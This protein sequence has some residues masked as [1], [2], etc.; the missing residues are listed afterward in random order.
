MTTFEIR[1]PKSTEATPEPFTH[2]LATLANQSPPALLRRLFMGESTPAVFL[3]LLA[4]KQAIHYLFSCPEYLKSY[5]TNQLAAHY[6]TSQFLEA[7]DLT[8]IFSSQ[9]A[10]NRQQKTG[11]NKHQSSII[12]HQSSIINELAYG[13]MELSHPY[14]YPINTYRAFREKDPMASILSIL[15]RLDEHESALVQFVLMPAGSGWQESTQRMLDAGTTDPTTKRRLALPNER[16][17]RE[18]IVLNGLYAGIRLLVRS[19]TKQHASARMNDLA[20]AFG[21]FSRGDGNSLVLKRP[22][23]FDR[24][25]LITSIVRRKTTS[26]PRF[27]VLNIEE[28]ASLYHPPTS[29]LTGVKNIAWGG[30]LLSEAPEN[31]PISIKNPTH[32]KSPNLPSKIHH[33]ISEINFF[34]KTEFKNELRTFGIKREDRRR[35]QYIIGKTGTG[36][37]TM[38]ANMAINDMRNGE[39]LAV[40]DPH[41]DLCEIILDYIPSSRINDVAY[42]DP[43]DI[44]YPFRLNPLELTQGSKAASDAGEAGKQ[45]NQYAAEMVAS[46]IVSIFHK[47]YY[48]SWGPRLEYMLRNTLLTLTQIPNSTLNDVLRMLSDQKFRTETLT[49]LDDRVLKNFWE[50]EFEKMSDKLQSEAISPILNKIGQFVTSPLIRNIIDHPKSTVDFAKL[51]DEKKIILANLSQGKLGEDNAALMGAMFITKMQL[52]AMS[53]VMQAEEE[54]QDFY[55]YVDEFQ[56]FATRSFLK[57]LSEARKYRLNLIL[58]N[59]YV[60]QIDEDVKKAIFGNVGSLVSFLVGAQDA[61]A[62]SFEFGKKYEDTD[63]VSLDNYQILLK[64]AIDGRTSSPFYAQTLPLPKEKNKNREKVIRVSRERYGR[65]TK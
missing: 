38:I 33:D 16:T 12:N 62:L 29:L 19:T 6:P 60:G 37:S 44:Q 41:G 3:E 13:S 18:K 58:A 46:G 55:L 52:A 14:Y 25:K 56:N 2:V 43:S 42:L 32:P 4:Y 31:L 30:Q 35:H 20:G 51:M 39:G 63:F 59:Q 11:K 61:K 26:M 9:I 28:I 8:K 49:K 48:Y 15:A 45:F 1:L 21:V 5:F 23:L 57:I 27:Q 24:N 65:A 7:P 40:I 10:D 53:R 50:N 17:I 64:M 47:L 22:G 54:R 34:A 36:K